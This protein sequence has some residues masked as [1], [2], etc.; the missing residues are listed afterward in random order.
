[1]PTS[2]TYLGRKRNRGMQMHSNSAEDVEGGRWCET[3]NWKCSPECR[4]ERICYT[5]L[6]FLLILRIIS[7]LRVE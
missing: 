1:M 7:A 4:I 2:P 6:L 3:I 5:L